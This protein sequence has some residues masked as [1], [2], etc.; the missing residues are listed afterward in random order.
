MSND[1]KPTLAVTVPIINKIIDNLD[2]CL[3]WLITSKC[4]CFVAL[5][6]FCVQSSHFPGPAFQGL[7]STKMSLFVLTSC[8]ICPWKLTFNYKLLIKFYLVRCQIQK[9]DAKINKLRN[10]FCSTLAPKKINSTETHSHFTTSFLL[11]S[12]SSITYKIKLL[13][14]VF[15]FAL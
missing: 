9:I 4:R 10:I 5:T 11:S 2:S 12:T 7:V 14:V 3:G 6:W 15:T 8:L 13:L 1:H